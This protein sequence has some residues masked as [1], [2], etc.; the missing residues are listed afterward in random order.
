MQTFG[1][2]IAVVLVSISAL[3]AVGMAAGVW[4]ALSATRPDLL[5]R[6]RRGERGPG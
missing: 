1:M 3:A 4:L 2:I 6:R 5:E